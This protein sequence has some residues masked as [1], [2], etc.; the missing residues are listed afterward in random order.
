MSIF[1]KILMGLL[2]LLV[3]AISSWLKFGDLEA[4]KRWWA[5]R[6]APSASAPVASVPP[7]EEVLP[8]RQ[9]YSGTIASGRDGV[10]VLHFRR[11]DGA[12]DMLAKGDVK[13]FDGDG[14]LRKDI[15]AWGGFRKETPAGAS[16]A[17]FAI[18]SFP[19]GSY[20]VVVELGSRQSLGVKRA[21]I[22]FATRDAE[23]VWAE[24]A[25]GK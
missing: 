8:V 18:G 23:P 6:P 15:G 14:A 13:V 17:R 25:K 2:V 11:A 7:A 16:M 24:L 12:E 9:S 10:M 4:A 20:R 5:N 3:A 21:A 22:E 19:P 1:R